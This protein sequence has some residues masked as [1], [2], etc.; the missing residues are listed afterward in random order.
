M[1]RILLILVI[2]FCPA[3][4][5]AQL[6]GENTMFL[7]NEN[8]TKIGI[9]FNG[10]ANSS[11]IA[12]S[13]LAK[14]YRSN[15]ILTRQELQTS[16]SELK[17]TNYSGANVWV[18]AFYQKRLWRKSIQY[19][20]ISFEYIDLISARF[21]G[22]LLG[23]ATL[24]NK[25]YEDRTANFKNTR[26]M[27]YNAQKVGFYIGKNL[28]KKTKI[29]L[30][31]SLLKGGRYQTGKTKSGSLYTALYGEY[32]EG[33]VDFTYSTTP[34]K[35]AYNFLGYGSV[36]D[37]HWS[38]QLMDTSLI[39]LGINDV[40]IMNWTSIETIALDTSFY[41]EGLVVDNIFDSIN[42]STNNI[43]PDSL[44]SIF[45]VEKRT[46]NKWVLT[47]FTVFV[48]YK[49]KISNKTNLT[50]GAQY[51]FGTSLLP[52]ITT[53]VDY[54]INEKLLIYPILSYGG[55]GSYNIGFGVDKSIGDK[56]NLRIQSRFLD[57]LAMYSKKGGQGVFLSL[58]YKL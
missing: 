22:D 40:G 8:K 31:I 46:K 3:I 30:G 33:E 36:I 11:T 5:F 49:R 34:K 2:I 39:S 44:E 52:L 56:T 25:A 7:H 6:L 4:N 29:D 18:R 23:L 12:N 55:F 21:S 16:V 14:L 20:R 10:E 43:S 26:F 35:K 50:I 32:L 27:N 38:H 9:Q 37:L 1:N 57:G 48:N 28:D 51:T 24:G 42:L 47:P 15:Q 54:R 13:S 58:I 53:I 45:G 19:W 17:K 41:F